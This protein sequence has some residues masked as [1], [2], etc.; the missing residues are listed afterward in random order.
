MYVLGGIRQSGI[1]RILSKISSIRSQFEMKQ[2]ISESLQELNIN[3]TLK[4]LWNKSMINER[5]AYS[6]KWRNS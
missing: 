1:L 3:L 2:D 5:K 4:N 6:E